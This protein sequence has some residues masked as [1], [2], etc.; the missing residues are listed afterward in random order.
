MDISN[1]R[2]AYCQRFAEIA[3]NYAGLDWEKFVKTNEKYL[4]PNEVEYLLGD[5]SKARKNLNG[6][7]VSF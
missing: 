3:F 2:N 6:T 4:R 1:W 7:K 5:S